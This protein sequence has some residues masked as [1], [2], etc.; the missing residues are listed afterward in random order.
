MIK[1]F[2][3]FYN[4]LMKLKQYHAI[5]ILIIPSALFFIIFHI[6]F[7]IIIIIDGRSTNDIYEAGLISFVLFII[8]LAIAIF[9]VF[10]ALFVEILILIIQY[11]QN[12][13]LYVKSNFL[14]NSKFYNI[15]Y[16]LTLVNYL[17][18]ISGNKIEF[19]ISL[20]DY[21]YMMFLLPW[22]YLFFR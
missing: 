12:R 17:I 9:S 16:I 1:C 2:K 14:L 15:I 6:L 3:F 22:G 20:Y 13:K 5:H 7:W 21:S 10:T 18:I 11:I 19:P 4:L 8:Y